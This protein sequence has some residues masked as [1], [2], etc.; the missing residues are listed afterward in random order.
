M[1]GKKKKGKEEQQSEQGGNSAENENVE[2]AGI[3]HDKED[4][5]STSSNGD[6]LDIKPTLI[7]AV[8]AMVS[9]VCAFVFVTKMNS[10]Q[11]EIVSDAEEIDSNNEPTETVSEEV[12]EDKADK[13]KKKEK[14]K[15]SKGDDAEKKD[16]E[17][18]DESTVEPQGNIIVP[19]ESIVVNLGGVGSRRYLRVLINLEVENVEAQE[20][21]KEKIV[22][23]RDKMISLLSAKSAKEI[24]TEGS[25]LRL[26]LEIKNILNE[27]LGAGD[28]IKQIYFSDFIIQ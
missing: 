21:I 9:V 7:I 8:I 24:E 27:L 13:T 12:S 1:F 5:S 11:R 6:T 10:P 15:Q 3:S 22:M 17:S 19:L 23:L 2:G 4:T 25:L 14:K 16:N 18:G 28:T 20:K 26:R